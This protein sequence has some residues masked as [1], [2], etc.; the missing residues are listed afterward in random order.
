MLYFDN[1]FVIGDVHGHLDVIPDFI[2]EHELDNCAVI[3]AGDF[4]IGF[5]PQKKE[6]RRLKYLNDRLKTTKSVV[7][8]VRGNHDDPKYYTGKFDTECVKLV[9]DYTV[10]EIN[11]MDILCVG[12]AVSIDR[13]NRKR[14]ITGKGNDWWKDEVFVYDKDKVDQLGNV[15]VVVTHTAPHFAYPF[16]KGNLDYW[17]NLD[18]H[19]N[20][21]VAVERH[22]VTMLYQHLVEKGNRIAKWYYGHFH[23]KHTLPYEN[24]TFVALNINQIEVVKF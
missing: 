24:T 13:K 15:D 14:Y 17:I 16:T 18:I 19:L 23:M 2:K 20:T 10:L 5:E 9:P 4:G 22:D 12:G 6:L 3:V 11:L 8:A 21:D 1:I 7:Y